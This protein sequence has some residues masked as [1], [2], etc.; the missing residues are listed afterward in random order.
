M[1]TLLRE[2][3]EGV[4]VG[5]GEAEWGIAELLRQTVKS[6][7]QNRARERG[8]RQFRSRKE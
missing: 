1:M 7:S 6:V 2:R 5:E 4:G 8:G 3:E